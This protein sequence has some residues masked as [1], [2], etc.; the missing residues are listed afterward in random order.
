MLY[1]TGHV[2]ASHTV[3][4]GA[5]SQL[6]APYLQGQRHLLDDSILEPS[7]SASSQSSVH[8]LGTDFLSISAVCFYIVL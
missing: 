7:P 5:C 3:S 2:K 4:A 6:T 1:S 8:A